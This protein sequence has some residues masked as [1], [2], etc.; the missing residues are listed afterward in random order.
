MKIRPLFVVLLL[1]TV[2]LAVYF[3]TMYAPFN[4]VDDQVFATRL[5]NQKSFSLAQHIKPGGQGGYYRPLLTLSFQIDK[6]VGGLHE[7]FMH[8]FNIF[9]HVLNV[10]LVF[11][12]ARSI[13]RVVR[14]EGLFAPAIAALLFALH[15][16]NSEAVNWISAR[17]DLLAGSFVFASLVLLLRSLEQRSFFW[18]GLAALTFFGGALCKETALFLL[19]GVFLVMIWKTGRDRDQWLGRWFI[20][21]GYLVSVLG[22]FSLR[23][24]AYL[25]DRGLQKTSSLVARAVTSGTAQGPDISMPSTAFPWLDAVRVLLK[26]IGFYTVKLFQP[27]PLNF[28]ITKIHWAYLIVGVILLVILMVLMWRRR[29]IGTLFVIAAG[30]AGSAL[31]VLFANLAWTPVAERYMYIPS[32]L[33]AISLAYGGAVELRK[34]GKQRIAAF[35]VC[36]VLVLAGWSTFR[37]NLIW[38]DNLTL[39]EDTVQKSPDFPPARNELAMALYA[40][41]RDK[42]AREIISHINMPE[43]QRASL[44]MAGVYVRRGDYQAARDFLL[45]RLQNPGVLKH[46]ILEMLIKVASQEA[47]E[48]DDASLKRRNYLD[49][50]NWLEQL[51]DNPFLHYRKGRIYLWLGNH[52]EALAH[53]KKAAK[54]LPDDSAFKAAAIKLSKSLEDTEGE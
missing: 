43:S 18:G 12:L 39:F 20:F 53:F 6:Y 5:L 38:Q 34:F 27:L 44:N 29:P 8:T 10:I 11:F 17:S 40:H 48:T 16:I 45:V 50:L 36:L 51:G 28:A 47:E 7:V 42:E 35:G 19:P 25:N 54:G 41:G 52:Q 3:P 9:I 32:G 22:Y 21:G 4:S 23:W 30:I 37:R 1:I 26:S 15:P 24:G 46:R 2:A 31:F 33:F 49:I 14:F 13:G